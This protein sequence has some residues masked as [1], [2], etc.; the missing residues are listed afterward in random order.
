[1][2]VGELPLTVNGKLD[3]AALPA[4]TF[5]TETARARARERARSAC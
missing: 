1:M 3:V 4:A 2:A 5:T